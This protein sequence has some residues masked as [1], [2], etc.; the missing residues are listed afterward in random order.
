MGNT[1]GHHDCRDWQ[2]QPQSLETQSLRQRVI[3]LCR[4]APRI[5]VSHTQIPK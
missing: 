1:P 4:W 3:L 5:L 2:Y